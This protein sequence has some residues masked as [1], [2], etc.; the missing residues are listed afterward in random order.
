MQSCRQGE[1]K[2]KTS[3]R[4]SEKTE[5]KTI[6]D[7]VAADYRTA[8][9]FEKYGI[10]FCCGGKVELSTACREK[11]IDLEQLLQDIEKLATQ[12]VDRSQNYAAWDLPFLADYIVNTHH[13][14]LKENTDSIVAYLH[15]IAEVHGGH[16]PEVIEIA[17]IF[18]KMAADLELHLR[19]EEE[20]L[21]P[22][23]RVI[24]ALAKT[25][26]GQ[27]GGDVEALRASIKSLTHEHD[28]IGA[29]IHLIRHLA[30][31]YAIP[32]D[33]CNTFMVAY[34]KLKEFEDDLHKHVH[35]ENNI[36]FMKAAKL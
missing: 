29:A 3:E 21:F 20:M 12:P 26:S 16:H 5:A 22:A 36:L 35:L 6:G 19:E 10:D 11:G 2:V 34:R 33:V 32:S 4:T 31:D 30:K 28:E 18:D 25:G 13:V 15:K 9:V 1:F 7:I 23:I 27:T 17:G 24:S 8:E 14:Y